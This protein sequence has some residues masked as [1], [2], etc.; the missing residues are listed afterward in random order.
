MLK[1]N[2]ARDEQVVVLPNGVDDVW[3]DRP[4]R[5]S[6]GIGIRLLLVGR[7]EYRK[8][9]H[10]LEKALSRIK[11]PID[12]HLVGDWPKLDST[13]HNLTYHGVVRDKNKMIDIMDSCD[14]LLVPS[15]SEGMPTVV[16]E[17][18]ARRLQVIATDVGAMSELEHDL[19]PPGSAKDLAA[20]I[21]DFDDKK[22]TTELPV[23]YKWSEIAQCT[24][25]ALVENH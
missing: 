12:L 5:V 13:H 18:K 22:D 7:H 21:L 24:L 19:I 6:K 14:V 15:L 8:G 11:K 9:F 25:D 16:L 23:Q 4:P 3:F 17:A 1:A 20:A 10:I 2:G